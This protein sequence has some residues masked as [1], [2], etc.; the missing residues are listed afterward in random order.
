MTDV[1][2]RAQPHADRAGDPLDG[3]VN[4]FDLGVVLAVAFLIAGIGV[5]QLVAKQ[6]AAADRTSGSSIVVGRDQQV[7]PLKPG[8]RRVAVSGGA[9]SVG[10]VY[11]LADGQLVYVAKRSADAAP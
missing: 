6:G 7:L 11:R 8:E 3:L 1:R 2:R 10:Q 5:S 4:M 9:T